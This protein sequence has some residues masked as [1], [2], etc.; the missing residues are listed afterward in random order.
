MGK[1]KRI[2]IILSISFS[3]LFC[4]N[5]IKEDNR[6]VSKN[7]LFLSSFNKYI[8]DTNHVDIGQDNYLF[9]KE[10]QVYNVSLEAISIYD[11][12]NEYVGFTF[13][14]MKQHI[15]IDPILELSIVLS[16]DSFK[17]NN[18]TLNSNELSSNLFYTLLFS[19]SKD[20]S[21][22]IF[23]IC[24][25]SDKRYYS[26]GKVAIIYLSLDQDIYDIQKLNMLKRVLNNLF[27]SYYRRRNEISML[28]SNKP[29]TELNYLE[30]QSIDRLVPI[31]IVIHIRD[32]IL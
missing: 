15:N 5:Q 9:S 7:S 19:C 27:E 24:T 18:K 26:S 3:C 29:F 17:I 2:L 16:N 8:F 21:V 14:I 12:V 22:R 25:I 11:D 4:T 31:K 30:Q 23:R 32:K 13:D 1:L 6:L 10:N 20:D 28:R